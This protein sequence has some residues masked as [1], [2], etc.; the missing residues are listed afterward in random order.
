[1]PRTMVHPMWGTLI[2]CSEV[3]TADH[4]E[5]YPDHTDL[6]FE[7]CE[8]CSRLLCVCVTCGRY[9]ACCPCGAHHAWECPWPL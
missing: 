8:Q 9:V 4:F 5:L 6:Q 7:F 1:M 2:T 3:T